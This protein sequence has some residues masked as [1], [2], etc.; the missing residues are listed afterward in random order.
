MKQAA[1][2]GVSSKKKEGKRGETENMRTKTESKESS[3]PLV[4]L[5]E[6]GQLIEINVLSGRAERREKSRLAVRELDA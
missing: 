6:C 5:T 3:L 2:Y 1:N 4:E